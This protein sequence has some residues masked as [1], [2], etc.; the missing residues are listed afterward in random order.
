MFGMLFDDEEEI[1]FDK[2]K[3]RVINNMMDTI[4]RGSGLYG[5]AVST[6][7][8]MVNRFMYESNKPRNPDYTYVMLEGL[9]LSPPIGSKARKIYSA[10]QSYKFD[11]D[12][13]I[14]RG[15]SLDN[16]AYLAAGNVLSGLANIPLDRAFMI[17]NNVR[18]ASNSEN[19]AWQRVA[20]MLGWNTWDVGV[21]P[22]E[23][24]SDSPKRKT[25]QRKT[26]TRK[27][28]KRNK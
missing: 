15:F 9:N 2:K 23:D 19:E 18:E 10:T 26:P 20:M 14:E 3:S 12:L 1:D 22:Y 27:T 17:L 21:N 4:L 25:P 6:I 5:A 11:R 7:K 16:P 28:P 24:E 13:M 8:N